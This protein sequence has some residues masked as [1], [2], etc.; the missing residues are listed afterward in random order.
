MEFESTANRL[1]ELLFSFRELSAIKYLN[2][3]ELEHWNLDSLLSTL[4]NSLIGAGWL[5]PHMITDDRSMVWLIDPLVKPA[6][7]DFNL[8]KQN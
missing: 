6:A 3:L 2:I 1:A 4:T 5:P 8:W 7:A